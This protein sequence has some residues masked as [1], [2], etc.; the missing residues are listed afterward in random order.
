MI[1]VTIFAYLLVRITLIW[2][3]VKV[4][5][6]FLLGIYSDAVAVRYYENQPSKISLFWFQGIFSEILIS[7]MDEKMN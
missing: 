3:N 4:E 2:E 7:K 1:K 5:I 6:I